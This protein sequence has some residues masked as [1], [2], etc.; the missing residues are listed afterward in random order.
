[1]HLR[2]ERPAPSWSLHTDH[3]ERYAYFTNAFSDEE[4]QKIVDLGKSFEL[5]D[6]TIGGNYNVTDVSKSIR[7]SKIVFIGAINEMEWVYRRLTDVVLNLNN[8]YFRFDLFG[9]NEALQFT[10]Y[11]APSGKYDFH[12][13]RTPHGT[14]RKLSI[15][16]QLTD[17]NEYE[18]GDFEIM[19]GTEIEKLPRSRGTVMAFPSYMLHRVSTITKGTRHSLVGW[20]TGQPFK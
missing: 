19:D 14:V 20:I 1:M 16:L 13:D 4:C 10:E 2:D 18:G 9:F 8:S 12:V 5:Y 6:G 11:N 17:P 15:V 7:D 3:V